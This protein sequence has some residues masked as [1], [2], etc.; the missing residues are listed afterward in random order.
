M[1]GLNNVVVVDRGGHKGLS[2]LR[3]LERRIFSGCGNL[4]EMSVYD[5]SY[6]LKSIG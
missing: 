4:T 2:I 1:K 3:Y 6:S 5:L